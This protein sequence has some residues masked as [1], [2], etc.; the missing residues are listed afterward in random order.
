MQY[1]DPYNKLRGNLTRLVGAVETNTLMSNVTANSA[2]L[3]S[4]MPM[5]MLNQVSRGELSREDY[6]ERY[7]HRSPHELELSAPGWDEDPDWLDKQLED[8][9]TGT[10]KAEERLAEHRGEWEIAWKRFETIFPHK[11]KKIRKRLD[12]VAASAR[13]REAVRSEVTRITRVIRQYL[14]QV[15]KVT[16][17]DEDIFFLSLDEMV[18]ALGGKEISGAQILAQRVAYEKYSSLPAYPSLIIGSFD[19]IKWADDPNHRSDYFDSRSTGI[20]LSN[21][22][23]G[24]AGASGCVEGTVRRVDCAEDGFQI[25]EGEILVTVTTNVG[26]TPIF[27]RLSAIVTDVGA[28]LSHAAIVARELGIPAVVGCGNATTQLKTGDRVRVDGGQGIVEIL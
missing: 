11:A 6:L 13:D 9:T 18:D 7:G 14:L 8:P 17:L 4:L 3:E 15:G 26:W 5:V 19:P 21:V 10:V 24:F 27:P 2:K 23:K 1:T 25:Q 28:P 20:D 16:G 12:M 22:I